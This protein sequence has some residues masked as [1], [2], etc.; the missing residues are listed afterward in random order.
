M[1]YEE[2]LNL[3]NGYNGYTPPPNVY[4]SSDTASANKSDDAL[5]V[6]SLA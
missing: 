3:W 4:E 2:I 1:S 5:A 6:E